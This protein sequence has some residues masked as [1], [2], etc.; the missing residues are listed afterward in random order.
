MKTISIKLLLLIS[1]L[2]IAIG[3]E[4]DD[5]NIQ[6]QNQNNFVQ[7]FITFREFD[8]KDIYNKAILQ[9]SLQ[10]FEKKRLKENKSNSNQFLIDSTK[11]AHIE[12]GEGYSS[13][14]FIIR[15]KPSDTLVKNIIINRYQDGS[16]L[17]LL[18][19]YRLDRPISE[20]STLEYGISIKSTRLTRLVEPDLSFESKSGEICVDIISSSA[21]NEC[22]YALTKPRDEHPE[23]FNND[24]TPKT[25]IVT[26]IESICSGGGGGSNGGYTNTNPD[27]DGFNPFNPILIGG[28][29]DGNSITSN[30]G[31]NNSNEE[32]S[33]C[34]VEGIIN[35]IDDGNGN[36]VTGLTVPLIN[37]SNDLSAY[38]LFISGLDSDL[39]LKWNTLSD[40][41][42]NKIEAFLEAN[43]VNNLYTDEAKAFAEE[44]IKIWNE[45]QE[46]EVDFEDR[47]INN[48]E[49]KSLDVYNNLKNLS[50][51]FKILIKKFEPTFPVSHL[52]FELGDLGTARGQTI[53]PNSSPGT[54]NSPNYIITVRLNNNTS[55]SGV[56]QR[57]ELL[58][59]KTI[60]HEVIHAEMFRKLLSVLDSGGTITGVTR[61]DI[62]DALDGDFPG[63]YDYYRRHKN[64]QHQQMATHY[65]ETLASALQEYDTGIPVPDNQQP[66][67]LYMDL[68]WEGLRYPNIDTWSNLSETE[69]DRINDVIADYIA[70]N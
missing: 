19:E 38:N 41:Q 25:I 32:Q 28:G 69:K 39:K 58:V 9:K 66:A 7:E 43:I 2:F 18:A 29:G 70:N 5:L 31:E 54:P 10:S 47:I 1:V 15:S 33:P 56:D 67:Q 27:D 16:E 49:G 65:R 64:W 53:A 11:I 63:M 22:T 17:C 21:K 34:E 40:S 44:V 68:S 6:K 59:A 50:S 61:Q 35:T 24:G 62:L 14:S 13:F 55:P 8:K 3:C 4:K 51:D 52:K 30:Y 36:C 23:C 48:L 26:S 20:V 45:N 46:A 57:P 42:Q 60:I 37:G 12:N